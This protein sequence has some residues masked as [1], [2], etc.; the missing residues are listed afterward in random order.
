MGITKPICPILVFDT[1]CFKC[2]EETRE[3]VVPLSIFIPSE[4]GSVI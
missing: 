2:V 1:L 4:K 3:V